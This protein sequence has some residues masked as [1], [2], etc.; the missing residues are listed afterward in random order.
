MQSCD[1]AEAGRLTGSRA[2]RICVIP[3]GDP[4]PRWNEVLELLD[5]LKMNLDGW[6]LDVLHASLLRCGEMWAAFT[7]AV[8]APRQNGKNEILQARELAGALILGEELII[9]SAHLAD[10]CMEAFMRMDDLID[11]SDWLSGQIRHVRRT[12]GREAIQFMNG[13]RVRF[14]TRTR[15]GGRGFSGSPVIFDEPMFFPVISQN[16]ILPIMSAQ[17]DPQAWYTG[18]AVDQ[19]EHEDGVV[20][21]RVRERALSG[22]DDRLA[23]FEWSL[24]AAA[25]DM[26]SDGDASNPTVWA[27]TNPALGI[28][29]TPGYIKAEREELTPRGFAVERLG[30]G[31][32]P[33]TDDSNES[34]IDLDVWDDLADPLASAVGDVCLAFDVSPERHSSIAS[35]GVTNQGKFVLEVIETGEGTSW[36]PERLRELYADLDVAQIVCDG[37]GPAV[38][39]AKQVDEAG[40]TVRRL[41]SNEHGQACG[42]LIDAI[43]DGNLCHLDQD[44]L[45]NA[46]R[47]SK[48]RPMVDAW[49]WSRRNS[50]VD[51]SPLVAATFAVW[52]ALDRD[53]ANSGIVVF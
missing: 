21:A 14:R 20:F 31:D 12:N 2:P 48:P 24:D 9:H 8:C 49:A 11:S 37:V 44:E 19:R 18:S 42:L 41:D 52:S 32:W 47:G 38:S 30:V 28:R 7:V 39:I 34:P 29:I 45:Q 40:I 53:I 22:E 15:G 13:A 16:A 26:V 33:D 17:P 5:R 23:Y 4:H 27:E 50:D 36:V 6:Q 46:I 10:T 35:V 1:S 51:I 43:N 3:D 25:P